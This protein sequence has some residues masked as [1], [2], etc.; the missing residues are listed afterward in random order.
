MSFV[1]SVSFDPK[2]DARRLYFLRKLRDEAR[3]ILGTAKEEYYKK[4]E[5][6]KFGD[7][8]AI[9]KTIPDLLRKIESQYERASRSVPDKPLQK[10]IPHS[11]CP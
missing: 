3:F 5:D 6:R 10:P 2:T 1:M 9:T 11:S 8:I 4:P 7:Y